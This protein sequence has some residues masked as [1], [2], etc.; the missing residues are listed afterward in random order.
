MGGGCALQGAV[1]IVRG[2]MDFFLGIFALGFFMSVGMKCVML[3]SFLCFGVDYFVFCV[4]CFLLFLFLGWMWV[5][6]DG[7]MG[8]RWMECGVGRSRWSVDLID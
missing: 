8:I 3:M 4:G 6:G 7:V 5:M 1:G 2:G